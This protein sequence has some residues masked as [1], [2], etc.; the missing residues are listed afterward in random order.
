M[1]ENKAPPVYTTTVQ[2]NPSGVFTG[3][4]MAVSMRWYRPE[5]LAQVR[6]ITAKLSKQHGEPVAWDWEGAKYLSVELKLKSKEID[7]GEWSEP[8]DGEIPVFWV[9][10]VTGEVALRAA[11]IPGLSMSHFPGAMFVT[12][13]TGQEAEKNSSI[14]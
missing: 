4:Y 8:Q 14:P 13:L 12:D 9:C 7:F 5:D 6:S 2:L 11:K 1:V 3:A 10:G